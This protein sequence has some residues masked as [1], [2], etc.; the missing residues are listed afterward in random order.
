[1]KLRFILKRARTDS[2]YGPNPDCRPSCASKACT[3]RR[4]DMA[5]RYDLPG[6]SRT[7]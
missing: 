4:S 3:L 2:R 5:A 7:S 6:D 1:M